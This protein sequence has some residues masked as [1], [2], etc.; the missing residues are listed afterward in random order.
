MTII[1]TDANEVFA[2]IHDR[3]PV[4]LEPDEQESWLESDDEDELQEL[5]DRYPDE[6][7]EPHEISCAVNNPSN[8]S[9]DVIEPVGHDQSE[10]GQFG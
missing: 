7:T 6:L 9:P 2:P 10:L 3:M 8:D 5:L 1:T 4:M